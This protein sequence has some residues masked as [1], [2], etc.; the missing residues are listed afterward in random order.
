MNC[1][2]LFLNGSRIVVLLLISLLLIISCSS[3]HRHQVRRSEILYKRGCILHSE[4]KLDDAMSK[5]AE[6]LSLAK[7][8][9]FRPGVVYNLN[10]M[11]TIYFSLGNHVKARE[12]LD[13]ALEISKELHM[14]VEVS[15]ALSNIAGTYLK[16]HNFKDAIK[17]Y[18]DLLEWDRKTNNEL[19]VAITLNNMGLIYQNHLHQL[20]EAKRKYSE[21]LI[22]FKEL[23]NRKYVE[24]IERNLVTLEP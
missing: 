15:K 11:A 13:E 10:E 6:S 2:I 24:L 17:I 8:A 1:N 4:G 16:E 21:A 3:V 12:M 9:G 22:I 19:G 7:K 14:Q 5:L 23:G 20:D 18:E